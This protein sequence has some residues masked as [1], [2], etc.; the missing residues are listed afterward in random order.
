MRKFVQTAN[1]VGVTGT[2]V[3]TFEGRPGDRILESRG[4]KKAK[5]PNVFS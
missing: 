2:R 3:K 4:Y 1:P 5:S